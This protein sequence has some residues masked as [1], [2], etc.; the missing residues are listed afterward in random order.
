MGVLRS[1]T[2]REE[3]LVRSPLRAPRPTRGRGVSILGLQRAIQ[4][5]LGHTNVKTTERYTRHHEMAPVELIR[6]DR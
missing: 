2:L 1:Q 3:D 5:F 4:R 6:R